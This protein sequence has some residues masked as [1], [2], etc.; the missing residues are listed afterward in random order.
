M[1]TIF[2]SYRRDDSSGYAGRL[3]EALERRFGADAVFRDVDTLVAG[4]DFVAAIDQGLRA[5]RVALVVIGREWLAS[6]GGASRLDSPDDY[7]RIEVAGALARPDVLVVPVLVEGA[8]M[9]PRG[10]LPEDLQALSRRQA[11]SLRDETWDADVERLIRVVA[12]RIGSPG[13]L[14]EGPP[15]VAQGRRWVWGVGIAA[16]LFAAALLSQIVPRESGVPD[17]AG[18]QNGPGD[19]AA[20]GLGDA[21]PGGA[22]ATVPGAGGQASAGAGEA[23]A[24]TTLRAP[25]ASVAFGDVVYTLRGLSLVEG[26]PNPHL[27]IEMLLS[28]EGRSPVNFWDQTFRLVVDGVARAPESGLN[29]VVGGY[30]QQEGTLDFALPGAASEA[31]LRFVTGDQTAEVPLDLTAAGGPVATVTA[32]P[33]EP[34]L[35]TELPLMLLDRADRSYLLTSLTRQH[36]VNVTRLAATVRLDNR[37]RNTSYFGDGALRL[38]VDGQ[39]SAPFRSAGRGVPGNSAAAVEFVFDAPPSVRDVRLRLIDGE[40]S[41]DVA[42]TLP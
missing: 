10:A 12:P 2:I 36:F 1:P 6:Q 4:Q 3:H 7:V 29:E 31:T 33:A 15:A 27:R 28:N 25:V 41:R 24:G 26:D 9:P 30:A 38:V 35:G 13:V 39:P 11:L 34:V 20:P 17:G 5:C 14:T 23:G 21:Q 40:E 22:S 18:V 32:A 37:A 19:P 16:A 42:L 8:G